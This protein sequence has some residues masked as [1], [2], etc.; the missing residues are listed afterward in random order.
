[1][2]I[3]T[4]PIIAITVGDVSGIGPE[5]ALK[6]LQVG[7]VYSQCRPIVL[8]NYKILN[9]Y[10]KMLDL[11]VQLNVIKQV[12]EAKFSPGIVDLIDLGNIDMKMLAFG[13]GDAMTGRAMLEYTE[14]AVS[15][16]LKGNVHAV[17]GGPHS[18]SAV[19]KAG[20][21]FEGYPS[22]IAQLTE[23][24]EEEAFLMLV[25]SN[26]RIVNTTLHVSL[27]KSLDLLKKPLIEKAI[28]AANAAGRYVGLPFPKI[29][30]TG[31]NPHAGEG[32]MFG[33]EEQEEILPAIISAQADGIDVEG[34]FPS[35]TLFS[36]FSKFDICVAMY[37]DQA[38]IP[39]KMQ[40]SRQIAALTIGIPIIFA[41]LGHGSAPDIAGQG[42]AD[43]SGL[44]QTIQLLSS[45]EITN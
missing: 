6:A 34:P 44:I 37:H 26:L 30:V 41:S 45:M 39:I 27:R 16:A 21:A 13:E 35:D 31:I 38:H 1:M 25:S 18:K 42:L 7:E 36:D 20:V 10:I 8:G 11:P 19:Q 5:I 4:N 29:A 23:T 15:M 14:R 32:G 22:L 33:I 2:N 17:I 12:S 40:A 28:R 43:P 3:S 24:K 9:H